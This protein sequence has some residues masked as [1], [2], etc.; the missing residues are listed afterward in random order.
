MKELQV[1]SLEVLKPNKI[2]G[3]HKDKISIYSWFLIVKQRQVSLY[4]LI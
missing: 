2:K 1:S 4:W 3:Q